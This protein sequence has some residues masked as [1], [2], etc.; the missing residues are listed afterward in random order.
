MCPLFKERFNKQC[1]GLQMRIV[2]Y[3]VQNGAS[4]LHFAPDQKQNSKKNLLQD[5]CLNTAQTSSM[6][7]WTHGRSGLVRSIKNMRHESFPRLFSD[8]QMQESSL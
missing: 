4:L 3:F 8:T 6:T 1:N 5:A 7:Y 2:K